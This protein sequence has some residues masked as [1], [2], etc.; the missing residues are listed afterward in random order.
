[1]AFNWRA[2]GGPTLNVGF[3]ALWFPGGSGPV[4]LRNLHDSFVIFQRGLDPLSPSGSAHVYPVQL[5][6]SNCCM[7]WN[8]WPI[9]SWTRW[10]ISPLFQV[11]GGLLLNFYSHIQHFWFSRRSG[12]LPPF[13]SGFV[14]VTCFYGCLCFSKDI[15]STYT[16]QKWTS[17]TTIFYFCDKVLDKK[18][19]LKLNNVSQTSSKRFVETAS[20]CLFWCLNDV[21]FCVLS[22]IN[23]ILQLRMAGHVCMQEKELGW[24]QSPAGRRRRL[25]NAIDYNCL[26]LI[27]QKVLYPF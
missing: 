16:E 17:Y 19:L 15:S 14:H 2:D 3:L 26:F 11:G 22:F 10:S 1:M 24:E 5:V 8:S 20:I 12:P 25:V 6:E 23:W 21:P 9:V 13:P 7:S 4:L 27:I 18:Y